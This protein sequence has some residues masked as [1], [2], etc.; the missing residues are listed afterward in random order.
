MPLE[1][2]GPY[3]FYQL[4]VT[5]GL[6]ATQ[7][8]DGTLFSFRWGSSTLQAA[9]TKMELRLMQ[10][11]AATAT[12]FPRYQI[13]VARGFTVSDSVGTAVTITGNNMKCRTGMA[14]TGVTDIRFSAVAAGLTVGTRTLDANPVDEMVTNLTVTTPN[15]TPYELIYIPTYPIILAQNEGVIVRGPT[16]V[17]GAA[18]A[19]DLDVRIEWAEASAFV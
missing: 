14:T 6:V 8:V 18:G 17:F 19:A 9:I 15:N 4:D 2:I 7:A 5:V 16:T 13:F 1:R 12:I 11:V 3:N 10:T